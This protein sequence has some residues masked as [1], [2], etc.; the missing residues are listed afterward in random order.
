MN[1]LGPLHHFHQ[2]TYTLDIIKHATMA[3]CK[4]CTTPVDLQAKLA[5]DSRP[6]V[7]E[8]FQF[9]SIAGALQYLSFTR[10]D[11]AYVAQQ[12]YLHMQDPREPHLTAMKRILRYLQGTPDYSLL[13]RRLSS[14]DLVVYTY[15][16]WAGCPA[17]LRQAMRCS[18]GTTWCPSRPSGRPSSPT[19][20]QRPSIASSPTAWLRPLGFI[21]C[22]MSS[23]PCRLGAYLS[24]VTISMSCT[25]PPTTFSINAPSMWRL[26]FILF[27]RRHSADI[28]MKGLPSSVFNEFQSSLNICRD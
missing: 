20:I 12:I 1:D 2:C 27:E 28:F 21:S 5:A 6:P 26:I 16:D 7:Q 8:A 23:R 15:V 10:P 9:Q 4:P 11:I 19:P 25:Y 22:S 3:D 18:W 17:A 14:S 24:T 13:L